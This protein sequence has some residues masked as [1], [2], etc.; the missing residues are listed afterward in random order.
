M[1]DENKIEEDVKAANPIDEFLNN[2]KEQKLAEFCV[3]KDREIQNHK[4]EIQELI[5]K[6]VEM[7]DK[8]KKYDKIFESVEELYFEIKKMSIDDYLKLY[9]MILEDVSGYNTTPIATISP[10][11][12]GATT[13]NSSGR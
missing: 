4:H 3:Q 11:L 9:H 13:Y 8:V 10:G 1:S 6:L 12:L 2:Y 7:R 5:E